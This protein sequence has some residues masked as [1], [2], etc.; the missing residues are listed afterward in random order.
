MKP[1]EEL[2]HAVLLPAIDDLDVARLEPLLE[3]GCRSVLLGETREEYLARRMGDGRAA[4]ETGEF[5]AAAIAALKRASAEPLLIAVDHELVGIR[6]F[7]H[8]LSE[9]G[10][11]EQFATADEIRDRSRLAGEQLAPLGVNVVLGPIVDVVRGQNPWLERR[12]LGPDPAVVAAAGRAVV[13]GLLTS[14]VA[15][16]AK[17]Y[18][19]HATAALDP[20]IALARVT[21]PASELDTIDEAPFTAVVAAGVRGLMLGPAVVE[22]VDARETASCSAR[23]VKRA[24]TRLGFAGTL[25]SDDLD[26]VSILRGRQVGETAV[27]SLAAGV[28]LLLVAASAASECAAA[29]IDAV[30]EGRLPRS[31]LADAAANIGFLVLSPRVSVPA[32]SVTMS[33]LAKS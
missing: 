16:V 1:V 27:A 20:A 30:T 19:G 15:S 21:T 17:H 12:N 29:I 22:A 26:A 14:G 32:A 11:P 25:V 4:Q 31:R 3:R 33:P 7:A 9:A 2:A 8:L 5:V 24:R 10:Q 6:R 28:D 13:E 23:V 18:P